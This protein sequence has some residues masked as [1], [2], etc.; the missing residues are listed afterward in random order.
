MAAWKFPARLWL[1]LPPHWA[2]RSGYPALVPVVE[3][4][5]LRN[6]Y[7]APSGGGL[8]RLCFRG[9]LIQGEMGPGP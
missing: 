2:L 5:D 7:D 9:V 3:T 4:V 6:R 1:T 8:H